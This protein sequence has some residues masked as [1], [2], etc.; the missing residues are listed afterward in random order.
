MLKKRRETQE[1]QTQIAATTAKINYLKGAEMAMLDLAQSDAATVQRIELG[2][3]TAADAQLDK[4]LQSPLHLYDKGTPVVRGREGTHFQF[5][6][7]DF[8]EDDHQSEAVV[9]HE[10]SSIAQQQPQPT[11]VPPVIPPVQNTQV[12][13][14]GKIHPM[15]SSMQE[16]HMNRILENQNSLTRILVKQQFL[17]TLPQGSIPLFDGQILEYKSFIHSFESM[18]ESKTDNNRDRL[19]FLI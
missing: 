16:N 1:L 8:G 4:G 14:Q 17:S 7:L 19:Q 12:L 9:Q 15:S 6:L 2:T 10:A 13:S 3:S 5:P 18:V 11:S